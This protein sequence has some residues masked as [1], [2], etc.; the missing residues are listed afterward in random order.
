MSLFPGWQSLGVVTR[1]GDEIDSDSVL[2]GFQQPFEGRPWFAVADR[3][4]L[5]SG[6]VDQ[7]VGRGGAEDF[8]GLQCL[9]TAA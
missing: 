2:P 8:V 3:L 1:L 4:F 9:I 5:E 7:G 6:R